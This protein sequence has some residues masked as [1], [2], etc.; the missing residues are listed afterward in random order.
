[1]TKLLQ[2]VRREFRHINNISKSDSEK[3][4]RRRMLIEKIRSE[5]YLLS[6]LFHQFEETASIILILFIVTLNIMNF[7]IHLYGDILFLTIILISL[8]IYK[9]NSN[10]Q[11]QLL[12]STFS[13]Y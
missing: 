13:K 8:L 2:I 4:I 7:F 6:Y 9:I 5:T 3:I 12:K 1:M 10:T 11:T